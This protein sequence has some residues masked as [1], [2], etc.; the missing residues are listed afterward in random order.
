MRYTLVKLIMECKNFE[1]IMTGCYARVLLEMRQTRTNNQNQQQQNANNNPQTTGD[2]Y[3]IV[4]IKGVHK[5]PSYTGFSWDGV[6]TDYHILIEIPS[7][8]RSNN[9]ANNY[10]QLNSI[11]NSQF[12]PAE[13]EEWVKLHREANCPFQSISQLSLRYTTLHEH[14]EQ[15]KILNS[16]QNRN[17]SVP[18]EVQKKLREQAREEI[19]RDNVLLPQTEQLM[20]LSPDELYKIER[21]CHEMMEQLRVQVYTRTRCRACL[22][23]H[24]VII[25][26]PC[27]HQCLCEMCQD[28]PI[29]PVKNCGKVIQERIKPYV[30]S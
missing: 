14:L 4:K 16:R 28:V 10:V 20:S 6:T 3:F 30:E 13:Y 24:S 29:C 19:E 21:Q 26:Y 9:P 12:R 22:Q 17:E 7:C 1:S 15:I 25:C 18:E 27:K 11:S 23:R 2:N 5:G 8:F